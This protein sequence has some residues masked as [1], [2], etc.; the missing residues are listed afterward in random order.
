MQAGLASLGSALW[1]TSAFKISSWACQ[2]RGRPPMDAMSDLLSKSELLPCDAG[3]PSGAAL[4]QGRRLTT[5]AALLSI[6]ERRPSGLRR[7]WGSSASSRAPS[8]AS[9]ASSEQDP[10]EDVQMACNAP[11]EALRPRLPRSPGSSAS[12]D[13]DSAQGRPTGMSKVSCAAARM[14]LTVTLPCFASP[15]AAAGLAAVPLLGL[16]L[17]ATIEA[18]AGHTLGMVCLD[19]ASRT[20]R[21][22]LRHF[23][24][25]V[26]HHLV[27]CRALGPQPTAC[28]WKFQRTR[29]L[30]VAKGT[31][32]MAPI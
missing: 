32:G 29:P 19:T 7:F 31:Q 17:W 1:K 20:C 28:R 3:A 4:G 5:Q 16:W 22:D 9:R 2:T 27:S 6:R 18:T 30:M 8:V 10:A 24:E 12:S 26:L 14:P 13:L 21:C 25:A 11:N 23:L 15:L